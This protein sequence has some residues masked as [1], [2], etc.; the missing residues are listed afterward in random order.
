[1]NEWN[2]QV[3]RKPTF[4]T[5]LGRFMASKRLRSLSRLLMVVVAGLVLGGL[6]SLL[7]QSQLEI[8]LVFLPLVLG[9]IGALTLGVH[10]RHLLPS[11]MSVSVL[12]WAS[13]SLSLVVIAWLLHPAPPTPPEDESL[14]S[15]CLDAAF[16]PLFSIY[17]LAGQA[18]VMLVTWMTSSVLKFAWRKYHHYRELPLRR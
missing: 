11:I 6:G 7:S 17:F 12:I 18:F 13:Y 3:E 4:I 9:V 15:P 8:P 16:V 1:M 5:T 10:Y 14:C 2:D